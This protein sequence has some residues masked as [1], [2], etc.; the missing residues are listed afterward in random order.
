MSSS[1]TL[2]FRLSGGLSFLAVSQSRRTVPAT[3]TAMPAGGG[4]IPRPRSPFRI[5]RLSWPAGRNGTA[6]SNRE[7]PLSPSCSGCYV[8]GI[9]AGTV[10]I[11]F[12]IFAIRRFPVGNNPSCCRSR[13][14]RTW[15]TPG[16]RYRNPGYIGGPPLSSVYC[17]GTCCR[18]R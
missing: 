17:P 11:P 4:K 15:E 18:G 3:D 1:S 13:P 7:K 14:G 5:S 2:S 6:L 8:S 16:R 12:G 9:G 10:H